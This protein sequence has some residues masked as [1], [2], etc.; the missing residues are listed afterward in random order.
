MSVSDIEIRVT[1]RAVYCVL[2]ERALYCSLVI[3]VLH[4]ITDMDH[5][6]AYSGPCADSVWVEVIHG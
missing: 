6:S 3:D 4:I 2:R 1:R 5:G